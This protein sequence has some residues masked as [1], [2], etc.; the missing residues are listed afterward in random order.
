MTKE[1]YYTDSNPLTF[2]AYREAFIR[3][4]KSRQQESNYN[5]WLSGQYILEAIAAAFNKDVT[6]PT[7]PYGIEDKRNVSFNETE[8]E[9][10]IRKYEELSTIRALEIKHALAKNNE[11]KESLFDRMMK[12]KNKENNR[13]D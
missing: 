11:G 4:V 7:T 13:E 10:E 1:E 8:E 2:W 6:Y 5:A 3:N 9:Y 12:H